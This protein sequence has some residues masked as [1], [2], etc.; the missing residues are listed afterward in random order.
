MRRS[1][2]LRLL[3]IGVNPDFIERADRHESLAD[4]HIVAR[5]D[6]SARNDAIDLR[7]DVAVAQIELGLVEIALGDLKLGLGL[8]DVRRVGRQ[9]GE[10]GIDVAFFLERLDHVTGPLVER[11]DDAELSRTL[12]HRRLR[13]E[14]RRKGLIEIGRNLAEICFVGLRRQSQRG[15]DLTDIGQ[16]RDNVRA[17][18]QQD[19]LPPVVLRPWGIVRHHQFGGP[20]EVNLSQRE[21]GFALVDTGNLGAQQGD[22]V[23]DVLYGVL[24]RPAPAHGLR[25]DAAHFGPGHLQV[26]RR[27]ID[28]RLFDRDR[29]LKRLLVQLDQKVAFAHPVV[30]VDEN[31]RD[32]AFDA[33]GDE[34]DVTVDIC[35]IRRNRVER[36][37]DPGNAEP[38]GGRPGS[39]GP[40]RQAAFFAAGWPSASLVRPPQRRE[41]S[42]G[43]ARIGVAS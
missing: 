17:G 40:A 31:A 43:L 14:H 36:R 5:I 13:L 18:R 11:M 39:E 2:Q 15:A 33:G 21:L 8:L 24:Q 4:L 16:R 27:R 28:S 38:K 3:E 42:A 12:N 19:R 32:L 9:P 34:R 37:L 41:G 6:V 25:F 10:G 23:V 20:V 1:P 26:C 30:V 22:L 7:D 29:D 35:V